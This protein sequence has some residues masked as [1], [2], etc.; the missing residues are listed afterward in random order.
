MLLPETIPFTITIER[1]D[2]Y[3]FAGTWVS[4]RATYPLIGMFRSDG[5]RLYMVDND[6][7]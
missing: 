1:Q 4:P 6:G 5:K 7:T 3:R 2:G